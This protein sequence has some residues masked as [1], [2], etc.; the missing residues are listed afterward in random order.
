MTFDTA[1]QEA[2][3]LCLCGGGPMGKEPEPPKEEKTP[4]EH[5]Q[6]SLF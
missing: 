2:R 3:E 6:G 1:P 4:D 5:G